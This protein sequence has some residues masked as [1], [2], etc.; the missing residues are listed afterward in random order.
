MTTTITDTIRGVA[1]LSLS[2]TRSLECESN[3]ELP[4]YLRRTD[5]DTGLDVGAT[6]LRPFDTATTPTPGLGLTWELWDSDRDNLLAEGAATQ[7][8]VRAGLEIT[9]DTIPA[10]TDTMVIEYVN[11]SNP[12]LPTITQRTYTFEATDP[13]TALSGADQIRV[14]SALS[15]SAGIGTV[16]DRL[17][18]AINGTLDPGDIMSAGPGTQ[19]CEELVAYRSLTDTL[20]IEARDGGTWGNM[21]AVTT[22]GGYLPAAADF[23][24][25][26]LTGGTGKRG[27]ALT[28]DA[29]DLPNTLITA[30]DTQRRCYA[31]LF[32]LY[33]DH[34]AEAPARL[35]LVASPAQLH[36]TATT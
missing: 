35:K 11:L 24:D 29:G 31:D 4:L 30:P 20:V 26:P 3:Y 9:I 15:G 10:D 25:E 14:E 7:R 8:G 36:K 13:P 16:I 5:P 1:V 22:T 21:C 18:N 2:G 6:N 19:S 34:T 32:G 17:V 33:S 23:T 27:I 12:D 28:M